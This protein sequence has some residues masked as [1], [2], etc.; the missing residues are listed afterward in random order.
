[1]YNWSKKDLF[2]RDGVKKDLVIRCIEDA[3]IVLNNT[4]I[5]DDSLTLEQSIMPNSCLT[6]G[7]Y[8]S[9][10]LK[11]ETTEAKDLTG[12][13]LAAF[14]YLNG[15]STD[16]LPLGVFV[17]RECT[18]NAERTQ[19]ELVAYDYM[20]DIINTDMTDWYAYYW[21]TKTP[22]S[23]VAWHTFV[24]DMFSA[25]GISIANKPFAPTYYYKFQYSKNSIKVLKYSDSARTTL[26]TESDT[27]DTEG[28]HTFE[29]TFKMNYHPEGSGTWGYW[30]VYPLK[31]GIK[32]GGSTMDLD[33][34]LWLSTLSSGAIS[35]NTQVTHNTGIEP[36][37]YYMPNTPYYNVHIYQNIA[38][39]QVIS[40]GTLLTSLLEVGGF[41]GTI[42]RFGE[43]RFITLGSPAYTQELVALYPDSTIYPYNYTVSREASGTTYSS[44]VY[45]YP[46]GEQY[47]V[48]TIGPDKYETV[49]Y[50]DYYCL[51]ADFV[52]VL[53]EYNDID[54]NYYGYYM[55]GAVARTQIGP[56]N[57]CVIY[58]NWIAY[59]DHSQ[60]NTIAQCIYTRAH[61]MYYRPCELEMMGNPCLEVGDRILVV[62]PDFHHKTQVKFVTYILDRT[63]KGINHL[64]DTVTNNGSKYFN[65]PNVSTNERLSSIERQLASGIAA[66]DPVTILSVTELPAQPLNDVIYLIQ[67]E[68]VVF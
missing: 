26:V 2:W 36:D 4:N 29:N 35:E 68:V 40:G 28:D 19:R 63:L 66:N 6:F 10:C 67:G 55:D 52:Y 60:G 37:L 24:E 47:I 7:G 51:P 65:I 32:N 62:T 16:M 9:S 14:M 48:E 61:G 23:Y 17:V 25:L 56:E 54:G 30:Y 13:T 42:D 64:R 15:D 3:N 21:S 38:D 11:L 33:S 44:T 31:E 53:D 20:Y 41:F 50:E 43:F 8:S 22:G 1:M 18:W 5:V 39:T 45:T 46:S 57:P 49:E 58:N 27:F 34:H 12:Y 59:N